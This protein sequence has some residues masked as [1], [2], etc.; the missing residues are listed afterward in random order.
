MQ[1]DNEFHSK[2]KSLMDRFVFEVYDNT[3]N[4]PKEEVYSLTSQLRRAA[5]SVILNYI[6]GCARQRRAVLKNF[7]EISYGSLKEAK[8]LIYFSVRQGYLNKEKGKELLDLAEKIGAML[9]GILRKLK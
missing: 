3:K 7:L 9:W 1:G 4:F 5:L 2:F 6:E 8:Y